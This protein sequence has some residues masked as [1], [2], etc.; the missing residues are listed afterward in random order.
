MILKRVV[1]TGMGALTPIGNT[2][3]EYKEGLFSGTSGAGPITRFDATKFKTRFACEVKGLDMAQ[4]IPR[5]EARKMDLFTQ[6]AVVVGEEAVRD[7]GLDLE[8]VNLD[9]AGIIWGS[10]IGGLKTFE[11]EVLSFGSGDGTP[12]FNP[13]FIPKMIADSA[14]GILSMRMGFRGPTYVTVS[15]CASSN[16][17][18]IDAFNYI[19]LGKID[20]C[21]TGGS[22]AAVTQAGVGGFNSLKALSERN[23]DYL[24][25]SRPYDKD[26]D[27]FVLGEGGAGLILEE[28]EHALARGA[29]IYAEVIGGGMSS[30]AYHITAPHPDGIGAYMCMKNALEDAEISPEDIDYINTHGTS[31][32]IGDPQEIKA[33]ERLFGE[34]AYK[35]NI[36]STKSM[37]GHLLGGA[38]A[39]EAVACI[40]AIQHQLIPPTINHFTDD[41]EFSPR[42]NLTFNKPQSRTVNIALSNTFG[43][44]GH[45]TCVIFRKM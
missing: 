41:P 33:I 35:L 19:R 39:V 30:D 26:R 6:F 3:S 12:R 34:H 23:D 22:E 5:Q 43:F 11:E 13:F 37:I 1:V 15:A 32:P 28:Y 24:T 21:L 42:L 10:G 45:N 27:G 9:R 20:F 38:G 31:T 4:F 2:L 29:R 14:S 7:S 40:L 18:M 16:N 8:K 17:A 44:G 25:A 36:S